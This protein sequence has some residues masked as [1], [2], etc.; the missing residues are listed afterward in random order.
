MEPQDGAPHGRQVVLAPGETAELEISWYTP[1][2]ASLQEAY[3]ARPE[4]DVCSSAPDV[5]RVLGAE[6]FPVGKYGSTHVYIRAGD[7]DREGR[8]V[9][10]LSH[11]QKP[12]QA[13]L[14]RVQVAVRPRTGRQAACK[15]AA[16][17]LA[18]GTTAI[19]G[20][21]VGTVVALFKAD[22]PGSALTAW[23]DVIW[24]EWALLVGAMV[25]ASSS[26]SGLLAYWGRAP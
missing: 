9:I 12:Q 8:A 2:V 1:N 10:T 17:L 14:V 23:K 3:G 25:V 11:P 7:L 24:P 26:L 15:T 18:H 6:R 22:D 20:M 13:A 21:A 19:L 4:L 16:T 5:A